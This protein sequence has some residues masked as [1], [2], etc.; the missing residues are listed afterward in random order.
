[1]IVP[2]GELKD[3]VTAVLEASVTLAVKVTLCPPLSEVVPLGDKVMTTGF[4]VTVA[5]AVLVDRAKQ[6]A[7]EAVVDLVSNSLVSVTQL[8]GGIQPSIMLD[9]FAEAEQAVR[10]S[11]IFQ[12]AL[13]KRGVTE[14]DLVMIEPWSAGMYGTELLEDTGLRRL[15][16]LC[17]GEP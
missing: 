12:A 10:R 13:A 15:R 7:Y 2:T 6:A 14:I 5:L 1:M 17:S 9:E 3:Q 11:P 16:A 4:R 8:P